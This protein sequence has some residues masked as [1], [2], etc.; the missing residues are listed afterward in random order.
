M[1]AEGELYIDETC[2]D[3]FEKELNEA[4][5]EGKWRLDGSKYNHIW[6]D[7]KMPPVVEADILSRE[8]DKIIGVIVIEN[9][10]EQEYNDIEDSMFLRP[11]PDKI[12]KLDIGLKTDGVKK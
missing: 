6:D 9:K 3:V 2:R 5:G 10:Y 4:F 11:Y 7:T 1:T 12:R 8:T